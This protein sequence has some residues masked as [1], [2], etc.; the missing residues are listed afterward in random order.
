MSRTIACAVR[1]ADAILLRLAVLLIGVVVVAN[2]YRISR[3]THTINSLIDLKD[4]AALVEVLDALERVGA[5][6][7]D[8][9]ARTAARNERVQELKQS[10]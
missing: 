5:D 8:L 10:K 6:V 4:T 3:N 7:A 1:W 2:T 9:K